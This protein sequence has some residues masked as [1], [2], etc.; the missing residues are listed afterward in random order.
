MARGDGGIGQEELRRLAADL[1]N[2][3]WELLD[4]AERSRAEDDEM[5]HAAHASRFLW[6]RVGTAANLVR[7]EWQCA[8]VYST[9]GRAEPALWHARRCLELA[10]AAD[11]AELADFDLPGAYEGLARAHA[12][13]GDRDAARRWLERAREATRQVAEEDDREVLVAD[14]DQTTRLI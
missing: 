3:V 7:G 1:F 14:L 5:V 4:Q 13:A 11:S 2:R 8:R 6:G 10:E 12:V 9:L